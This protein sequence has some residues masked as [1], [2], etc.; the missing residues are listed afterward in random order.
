[1]RCTG[2]AV[3]WGVKLQVIGSIRGTDTFKADAMVLGRVSCVR[4]PSV[5]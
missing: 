4:R 2:S 1:M 3:T 5:G